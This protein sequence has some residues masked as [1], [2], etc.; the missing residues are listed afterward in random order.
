MTLEMVVIRVVTTCATEDDLVAAFARLTTDT[1]LF[2]PTK[3]MRTVGLE[4]GFSIR[5]AD[6]TPKLRGLCVVEGSYP[7]GDNAYRR[8]GV[9]LGIRKLTPDSERVFARLRDPMLPLIVSDTVQLSPEEARPTIEMAP[10]FADAPECVIEDE[11]TEAVETE[12]RTILGMPPLVPP[13]K[14]TEK[15][16]PIRAE[17]LRIT[18]SSPRAIVDEQAQRIKLPWRPRLRAWLGYL[19]RRLT[20]PAARRVPQ[21]R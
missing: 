11:P 3:A 17:M 4:T 6:G 10:L 9:L 21:A 12:R 7:D 8:S 18:R 2:V 20:A 1:T 16:Q 19:W 5:L 13:R 15:M 14:D